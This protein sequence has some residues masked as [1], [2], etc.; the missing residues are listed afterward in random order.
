MTSTATLTVNVR[1]I[2]DQNPEFLIDSCRENPNLEVCPGPGES[3]KYRSSVMSGRVE[4]VLSIT[5]DRIFAKDKDS[6]DAAVTY[7]FIDGS[8]LSYLQ[9]FSLDSK[10]GTVTQIKPVVSEVTH[11]FNITIKVR[12]VIYLFK[13]N[14]MWSTFY[15]YVKY[16]QTTQYD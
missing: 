16:F 4:G 11:N 15:A 13:V 6:L 3:P 14:W 2:D 9:Y 7:T 5:P 12:V 8:P 10:T 1:D